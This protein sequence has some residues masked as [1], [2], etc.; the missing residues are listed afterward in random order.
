MSPRTRK[1][2]DEEIFAAASRAM[3]R[4]GPAQL[5]LGEI[6]AD[7]GLTPAALV[8]RFGSKRRLLLAVAEKA[9]ETPTDLFIQLR[10]A[11]QS[12][13]DALRGYARCL[14]EMGSTPGTLA[15]NLAY[16]QI[17]LTD[18]DFHVHTRAMALATGRSLRDLLDAAIT[19]GELAT[20]TDTTELARIVQTV[21]GGSLISWAIHRDGTALD[22]VLL[23]LD[24]ILRPHV[25]RAGANE[26]RRSAARAPESKPVASRAST[27]GNSNSAHGS[28][29]SQGR[30]KPV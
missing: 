9:A 25:R 29:E 28:S 15:Q 16:L 11:H 19:A 27:R 6:A 12:P 23:D 14:A 5:T 17:D 18:P 21:L 22:R 26:K 8:Q 7:V 2:S 24:S 30:G 1:A 3:S 4:S 20:G 13:L 10:A